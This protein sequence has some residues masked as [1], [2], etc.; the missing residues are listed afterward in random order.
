[1]YESPIVNGGRSALP[2]NVSLARGSQL[3]LVVTDAGDGNAYDHADWLNAQIVC[4][5]TG[6]SV[7]SVTPAAGATSAPVSGAVIAVFSAAMNAATVN[8]GTFT[9]TLQG[10]STPVPAT[11]AYDVR[12]ATA[13]LSPLTDLAR[14]GSYTAV[15][16]GGAS[17]VKDLAG[18]ALA[19][20][21]TWTFITSNGTLSYLSDRPWTSATNGWGPVELDKSNGEQAA[22][23]GKPLTL[24]GTVF[25]KGLGAHA[26]SDIR[27][28]VTGCSAFTAKVGIDAESGTAGSVVFQVYVDG[29]LAFDSGTVTGGGAIRFVNVSLT[30]HSQLGLVVADAGDGPD[31]D[32]ADWADARLTCN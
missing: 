21:Y 13:T 25:A 5:A 22:G 11:I 26:P 14:G 17:G 23:D 29:A 7:S 4:A 16:K 2:I 24:A 31:Y 27:Y 12:S 10:A 28:N 19:S 6:P 32:H 9:L 3:R 20:D 18:N 15:L 30:G 8:A 1:V